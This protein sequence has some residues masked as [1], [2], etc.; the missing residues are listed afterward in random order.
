MG[1]RMGE[2]LTQH[3]PLTPLDVEEVLAEQGGTSRSFG[4]VALELGLCTPQHVWRAWV[5]QLAEGER[6]V[7]LDRVGIDAQAIAVLPPDVAIEFEVVPVRLID[8]VLVV[9]TTAERLAHARVHLPG[10]VGRSVRFAIAEADDVSRSIEVCY[11]PL[12]AEC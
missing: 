2:L 6:R 10:R 9:A 5:A 7:D 8:D 11:L 3:V 1:R 4:E 12:L